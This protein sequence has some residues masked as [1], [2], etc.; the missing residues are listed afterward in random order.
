VRITVGS[1]GLTQGTVEL[2]KRTETES[3]NVA[4]EDAVDA[5]LGALSGLQG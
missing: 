5:A 3:S 1:R 2:K 4:V